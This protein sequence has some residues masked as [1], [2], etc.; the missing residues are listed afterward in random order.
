MVSRRPQPTPDQLD[1]TESDVHV[2]HASLVLTPDSV[3]SRLRAVL[4]PEERA[5]AERFVFEDARVRFIAAHGLLRMIV[6]RYVNKRPETLT[7][8]P[9]R[10]GKPSLTGRFGA[11]EKIHFNLAHSHDYAL[12][13]VARNREVGIDLE[14]IRGDIESLKL[15]EQ[16]FLP[17]EFERL[18]HL[19]RDQANRLFFALWT[20][21]EAYLKARGTGLSLGL[22]RFE[23]QLVPEESMARVRLLGESRGHQ[24]CVIRILSLGPDYAGAV[25]AEGEDWRVSYRQWPE[26]ADQQQG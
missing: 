18:R 14:R 5:R 20:I 13:A 16:F 3:L 25:A 6:S 9:G 1:L 12:I 11:G 22:D 4:S 24:P 21:K 17:S 15:A 2:W 7:I 19:P 26:V 23:V 10:H 8:I